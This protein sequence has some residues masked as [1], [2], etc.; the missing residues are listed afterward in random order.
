M[1]KFKVSIIIPVYNVEKIFSRMF[2][3][4]CKSNVR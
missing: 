3:K 4:C 2:R 1:D